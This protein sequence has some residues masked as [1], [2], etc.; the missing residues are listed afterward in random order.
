MISIK[1]KLALNSIFVVIITVI[2]LEILIANIVKQNYYKNLEGN[3]Y[4]QI[5]IASGLYNKYFSDASLQDNVM[6]DV[7]TFWKSS[8]AQVQIV[9]SAGKILMDSIG[10]IPEKQVEMPD[11]KDALSGKKGFWVGKVD[12]DKE[13][14]MVV[15]YPLKSQDEVV[16]ALRFISSLRL[17]NED[18]GRVESVFLMIGAI[19]II[20][21]SIVSLLLSNS[22]IY[23]LKEVTQ[24]AEKMAAGNFNVQSVKK[25]DDEIGKLSD[26]L[27][28][29]ADEIQKREQLKNEF[30]SSVSH[31]LRTPLTS[32]KGWAVTLK[33]GS[34]DDKEMLQDGLE[35]IEKEADRLTSMVEELLDFSRFVS[36]KIAMKKE[37]VNIKSIVEHVSKQL[38]PRA[39][40]EKIEFVVSC[41]ENLPDIYTDENRLKQVFINILDNSLKFT[42]AG[43]RVM[44]KAY[45]GENEMLFYISDNG[46]GISEEELPKVKEKFYKGKNSKSRNGIG[47]SVC[48]EII[49]LM[50]GSFEI[51]SELNKGTETFISLPIM[52][53]D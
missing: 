39:D 32:I 22:I 3:M 52:K 34:L 31:E 40:R 12:Y 27:N 13:E 10:V 45:I 4:S 24:V 30:I 26:T 8:T 1:R 29:M 38:K 47:L 48:D 9:D 28:Y 33:E 46:C 2:I 44:F 21:S 53:E 6:N 7:D 49:K 25:N 43:G 35:I 5:K 16:G 23:P 11:V 17:V 50:N 14:V 41:E 51:R 20:I 19:V 36:G 15:S 42:S 37:K 18:V